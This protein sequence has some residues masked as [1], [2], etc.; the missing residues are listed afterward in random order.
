MCFACLHLQGILIGNQPG[1]TLSP[2]SILQNPRWPPITHYCHILESIDL[3]VM[4]LV[5]ISRF[6][7]SMKLLGTFS[8]F[9]IQ[10]GGQDG[11]Q[12]QLLLIL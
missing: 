1:D 8:Y 12:N 10:N 6:S 5:S 9:E 11:G 3:S 7:G 4:N 2:L